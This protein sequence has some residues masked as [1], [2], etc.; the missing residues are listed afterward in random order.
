MVFEASKRITVEEAL[1]HP[2]LS[3]LHFPEDEVTMQE[4]KGV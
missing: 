3:A 4:C 2:Y 1:E